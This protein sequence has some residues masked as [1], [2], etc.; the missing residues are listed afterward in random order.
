V[1][2]NSELDENGQVDFKGKAK[3]FVRTYNFLSSI[4]PYGNPSWEKLSI[5]LNFLVLKLPAPREEDLSR[6]ILETIDMESYR[7]EVKE[8]IRITLQDEDSEIEPI[9]IGG[10]GAKAD[11][12]LDYLSN[13]VRKFNELFGNIDWKDTDK[14]EKVISEELPRKVSEDKA[15]QNAMKQDDKENARIEHDKA[16][17][18]V[19]IDMLSDH[20]E[21]FKQ[22]MDNPGFKKWLADTI[23][24][25][26]YKK[27]A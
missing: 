10:G 6:G 3:S 11:P 15:Y 22:F 18:R 8:T 25:A 1:I 5:F 16:L 21:L 14:I 19:I 23:F 12:E 13:I 27:S 24:N 4:L 17:E 20:T 2:Y 26:T 7:A 9:L